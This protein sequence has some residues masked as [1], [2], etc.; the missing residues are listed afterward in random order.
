MDRN[1]Y[2]RGHVVQGWPEWS[3]PR[4][5]SAAEIPMDAKHAILRRAK[6]SHRGIG[7]RR[8][9]RG[10][11]AGAVDQAYLDEI[12][13]L[14][15]LEYLQ[16]GWPVT[17]RD[18]SPLERLTSLE[19]LKIDSPRNVTDFGLVLRL[20][21][22]RRLLI[23]NAK[24]IHDLA[25]LRGADHLWALGVE[26]SLWTTQVLDGVAPLAGLKMEALFFTSVRL[27]DKDLTP[28][29]DCPN[30]KYLGCARFAP[31]ANFDAL[32]AL[33]PDIA[34]AWFDRYEV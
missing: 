24:H 13:A 34:C 29:A 23:E 28:L 15:A 18:L 31:K 20:P 10:L 8:G 17:A 9:L 33:R 3:A 5:T 32:K 25:W 11:L 30:L 22:L 4:I 27:K 26:G 6:A 7:T 19:T 16:L 12:G 2:Y 1:A 14:T 21:R